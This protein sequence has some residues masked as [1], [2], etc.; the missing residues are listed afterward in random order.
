MVRDLL[1]HIVDKLFACSNI[2]VMDSV[3]LSLL[4][5]QGAGHVLEEEVDV[6]NGGTGGGSQ[7][8]E[9]ENGVTES[10]TVDLSKNGFGI[11]ELVCFVGSGDCK[12]QCKDYDELLHLTLVLFFIKITYSYTKYYAH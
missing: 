6:I 8:H 9:G 3:R 2:V 5:V 4:V 1:F 11:L 10:I 7:L 12:N